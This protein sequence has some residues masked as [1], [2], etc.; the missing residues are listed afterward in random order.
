MYS[1]CSNEGI[2]QAVYEAMACG[3]VVVSARVGGQAEVV[4]PECG[5]LVSPQVGTD[6]AC[7]YADV[8][9][10]LAVDATRRLEMSQ[11]SR[12][13]MVERFSIQQ[14]GDCIHTSLSKVIEYKK[15]EP[16]EPAI[17]RSQ[18]H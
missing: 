4:T 18:T 1:S 7:R 8:L 3:V 16:G 9:H 13:R 5:V 12:Q 6:V 11:A 15:N 14:M 2:S 17:A 10:D